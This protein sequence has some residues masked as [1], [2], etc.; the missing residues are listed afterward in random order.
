[1]ITPTLSP[2]D[3]Q[4]AIA[5]EAEAAAM[6]QAK[7]ARRQ[8]MLE[9]AKGRPAFLMQGSELISPDPMT[10]PQPGL[11]DGSGRIPGAAVIGTPEGDWA[12]MDPFRR[13]MVVQDQVESA[14][15][16][17]RMQEIDRFLAA[18][19]NPPRSNADLDKNIK[20]QLLKSGDDIW[21]IDPFT[22]ES[23]M[24]VSG[25]KKEPPTVRAYSQQDI[26]DNKDAIEKSKGVVRPHPTIPGY[27]EIDYPKQDPIQQ[28]LDGVKSKATPNG[29]PPQ[30]GYVIGKSYRG[31]IYL[32][33]DPEE[34]S[35]WS[36]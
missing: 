4:A 33:G 24:V 15:K 23:K 34:E 29:K 16:L 13:D 12:A 14:E 21:A 10:A 2:V 25:P 36:K 5:A 19:L 28:L 35:S 11:S 26:N 18:G 20:P 22:G 6:E 7:Q 17:R 27:F 8:K 32:G 3:E 1:M 31:M 9:E 30:G